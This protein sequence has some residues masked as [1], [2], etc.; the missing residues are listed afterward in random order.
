MCWQ[1]LSFMETIERLQ[2]HAKKIASGEHEKVKPGMEFRLTEAAAAGDGVWQGDLGLEVAAGRPPKGYVKTIR[3]HLKLVPGQTDGAKHCLDSTDGVEMW[4]P[5]EW[6]EDSLVGPFM[7]FSAERTITHP[8]HG[9][10]VIPAGLSILCRYQREWDR[11][12]AK[13]RRARD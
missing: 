11:E 9:P 10:V 6:T 13:E 2:R 1:G 5:T 7:R 4:V 12:L 8:V 3:P